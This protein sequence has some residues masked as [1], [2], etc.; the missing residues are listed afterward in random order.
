MSQWLHIYLSCVSF[1]FGACIGSFLNVC[2]H[3]LPRGLSIVSPP[4]HCPGCN[5]PIAW[6]DNIPLVSYLVLAGHCRKCDAWISPRYFLVE[7]LTGLLFLAVWLTANGPIIPV[8]WVLIGGLIAATFIDFEHYIIPDS[9]TIGGMVVGVVLSALVPELYVF[10]SQTVTRLGAVW[11]SVLG[12]VV[13]GVMVYA[14]V[15]FGKLV[16]GRRNLKVKPGSLLKIT[17][18]FMEL[19]DRKLPMAGWFPNGTGSIA[20]KARSVKFYDVL[21][22]NTPCTIFAD[23]M[24]IGDDMGL[25]KNMGNV[26]IV[27]D[28]PVVVGAEPF[29]VEAGTTLKICDRLLWVDDAKD[30]EETIEFV[31]LFSRESDRVKFHANKLTCDGREFTKV[32]VEVSET[33]V[34]VNGESIAIETALPLEA[35][36]DR[37]VIPREAMGLGD[38]KLMAAIGAFLGWKATVFTLMVSSVLGS[39]VGVTLILCRMRA[40][41]SKI[42]FGPYIAAGAL[43]WMF[44]GKTWVQMYIDLFQW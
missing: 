12:L 31:E 7:L 13:G 42:P 39:V 32:N 10:N 14:I 23:A 18:R 25:L 24:T 33:D 3:R 43:I 37:V 21:I 35:T 19:P 40:W 38:V 41:Q 9:L 16:F 17:G 28:E 27:L 44:G 15:E 20:F 30:G 1:L 2:V 5:T 22:E 8:Y 29:T 11:Q 6:Y 34:A 4:S 36:T 26:E